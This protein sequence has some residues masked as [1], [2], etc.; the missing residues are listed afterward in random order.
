M[1]KGKTGRSEWGLDMDP[2]RLDAAAHTARGLQT[3][4]PMQQW[5]RFPRGLPEYA[6][7]REIQ[8][9]DCDAAHP[10]DEIRALADE[11]GIRICFIPPGQTDILRPLDRAVFG[12][13]KAEHRAIY[14]YE[15][16]QREDKS[17]TKADFAA[18]V[19]LAWEL[20]SEDAIYRGW[21]CNRPDSGV[22]EGE[23]GAGL[24]SGP[25]LGASQCAVLFPVRGISAVPFTAGRPTPV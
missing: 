10:C 19:L 25:L 13:L 20:V 9:I 11:L 18:C 23:L 8:V 2:G 15:M 3:T 14:R 7:M 17:M 12:V 21:E 24:M 5:L 1:V 22:P 16:S 4:E 6:D